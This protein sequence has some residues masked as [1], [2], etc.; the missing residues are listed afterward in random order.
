M[1]GHGFLE[2]KYA[3][4]AAMNILSCQLVEGTTVTFG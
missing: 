4:Y 3:H 1:K 2:K